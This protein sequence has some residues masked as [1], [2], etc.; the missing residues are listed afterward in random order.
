MAF[1]APAAAVD[2]ENYSVD[3]PVSFERVLC[4]SGCELLHWII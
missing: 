3:N 1:L 2:E 4:E